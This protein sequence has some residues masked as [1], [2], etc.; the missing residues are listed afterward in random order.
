MENGQQQVLH[1]HG[2]FVLDA[3]LEHGQL[4][5]VAGFLV[6]HEFLRVDGTRDVVLAY[7]LLQEPLD[8][9]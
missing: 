2:L 7:L 9:L 5:N 6:E 4:E 1:I 8:A 3:G